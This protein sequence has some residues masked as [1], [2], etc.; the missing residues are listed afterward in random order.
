MDEKLLWHLV[1][2]REQEGRPVDA[3]EPQD[4]LPEEVANRGPEARPQILA[5]PGIRERAPVVDERVRPDVCDLRLVPRDRDSPRLTRTAD[6]EVLQTA[7]DEAPSLVVAECR[8]HEVA[9]FVVQRE[10]ATLVRRKPEEPVLL[11]DDRKISKSLGNVLDPLDLIDLYGAD[12]VRFWSAR[13][14]SFGQDG[15]ASIDD[16]R[17]RYERELANDLGNLLSRTTAMISRYL[18][19][20]LAARPS[21]DSPVRAL[22]EPLAADVAKRLDR[23]DITGAVERIWEVVRGLNR[24]VESQAPWQLAKDESRREELERTLYDLADGVRVVAIAL[25][26]Y[27][28]ETSPRILAALGGSPDEI[29]WDGVAYGLTPARDGVV[30][31]EP[32]Y[33]RI[34]APT[35]AA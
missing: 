13:A 11:L 32:L 1:A 8:E 16:L 7:G 20:R 25:A 33:P 15:S 5:R 19:G 31:A 22:V 26:A 10:Q 30:P 27:L 9:P 35:A 6:R 34:D 24:Y 28:P 23:Y 17:E 3:M 21:D 29:A 4:V 14:V 12:A 2:G 18:D